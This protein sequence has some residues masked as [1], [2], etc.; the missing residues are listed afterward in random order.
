MLYIIIT[1]LLTHECTF[2]FNANKMSIFN[3]IM[4]HPYVKKMV[5]W[6][7]H[8]IV[9][10]VVISVIVLVIVPRI[11]KGFNK[12][13][14]QQPVGILATI[15]GTIFE[16]D[17]LPYLVA[18]DSDGNLQSIDANEVLVPTGTIMIWGG[19]KDTAIPSGWQ[20]CDGSRGLSAEL[21]DMMVDNKVPN[22]TGRVVVGS[23]GGKGSLAEP[24]STDGNWDT[25]LEEA[26]LP[27]HKHRLTFGEGW[28]REGNDVKF[29][30]LPDG[31]YRTTATHLPDGCMG[32]KMDHR[33]VIDTGGH[34]Q[35]KDLV[36]G[37]HTADTG[38]GR[39]FSNT[40]PSFSL[41]YII[42]Y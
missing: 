23:N 17:N 11:H 5:Q 42:K 28:G 10:L 41:R 6:S 34:V 24:W 37:E 36:F 1:L 7:Y 9:I 3:K 13:R 40:Q 4:I 38:N 21:R 15:A 39:T 18:A 31:A 29:R 30:A 16:E 25:K 20:L 14:S 22:L 12:P 19:S 27:P 2:Y 26:D 8:I 33:G 35:P 32:C